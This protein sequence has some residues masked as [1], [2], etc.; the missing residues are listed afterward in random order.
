[1]VS[2]PIGEDLTCATFGLNKYGNVR[3]DKIMETGMF[4]EALFFKKSYGNLIAS[5]VSDCTV[6]VDIVSHWRT[7]I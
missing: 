5:L 1:M 4:K 2:K 3:I 6:E 7:R